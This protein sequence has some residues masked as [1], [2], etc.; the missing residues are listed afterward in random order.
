MKISIKRL[1]TRQQELFEENK[2]F[3][4]ENK[5]LFDE[6]KKL[7][8]EIAKLKDQNKTIEAR[9]KELEKHMKHIALGQLVT[10][11]E[12]NLAEFVLPPNV[13]VGIVGCGSFLE[14]WLI[15]NKENAKGKK[16][17]KILD[18]LLKKVNWKEEN[19]SVMEE[20]KYTR[21]LSAHPIVH[22]DEVKT[23]IDDLVLHWKDEMLV[24]TSAFE[25]IN[26]LMVLGRFSSNFKKIIDTSTPPTGY[27]KKVSV[28]KATW[29]NGKL[30]KKR[31]KTMLDGREWTN[32][33]RKVL[34][35][36]AKQD[37]PESILQAID[38]DEA[39]K[40]VVDY[41]TL[42]FKQQCFDIID[43][44]SKIPTEVWIEEEIVDEDFC[45]NNKQ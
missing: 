24:I 10:V 13:K 26:C 20:I 15:K 45:V 35:E 2:K 4:D 42:E 34:G 27:C 1:Q 31:W 44:M 30:E 5:K 40:H 29:K 11:L 14:K 39:K 18:K 32:K 38:F 41:I 23:A 22:L 19:W 7:R 3:F 6:N 25:M 16:G 33:H 43:V 8:E 36:M 21:N 9:V 37:R 12:K 28:Y 17:Q